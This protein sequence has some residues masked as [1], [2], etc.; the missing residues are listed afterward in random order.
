[1]LEA[2]CEIWPQAPIYTLIY[3]VRRTGRAFVSRQVRTSFLQ[4]IPGVKKHHRPFLMLMPLAIEQFD[5][6][7]YDLVVSDSASFAKGVI[8]RPQSFHLCYCHTPTRYVWDD[9]HRYIEEFSYP[10]LV[11][12]ILPPFL[13]YLRL[14]DEAAADRPDQYLANSEF[15]AARIKKYYGRQSQVIH[16]PV[17][18]D[19]FNTEDKPDNYFLIVARLLPYKKTDLA[20]SAF[21]EL[22]WP[23]KIIGDG[24]EKKR[25][26]KMARP[27]IEFIGLVSDEKLKKYY[28]R[29]RAFLFPQEED[30]GITAVEAMSAGRPV[31]AFAGG[32]ALEIVKEGETGVFFREQSTAS[33][34]EALNNFRPEGFNPVAIKNHARQFD[35]E[36]FKKK[37]KDYVEEQLKKTIKNYEKHI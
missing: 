15:V 14:W 11:K 20:V 25:L 13:S 17:K 28:A 30:F 5:L 29:C 2:F 32:G 10:A 26:Q 21:N 23:L 24:P 34:L 1:M 33:L 19:F 8:T 31:V 22:G 27:N 9:S 3:D 7:K 12:K 4:K 6:S 16:P 35:K 37:I 36:I 18:T